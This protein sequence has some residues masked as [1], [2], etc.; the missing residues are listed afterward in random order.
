M[1]GSA[2]MYSGTTYYFYVADTDSGSSLLSNPFT[3]TL[4]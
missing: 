4:N 3:L 1:G 2:Y